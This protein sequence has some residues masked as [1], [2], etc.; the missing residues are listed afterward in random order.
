MVSRQLVVT[1][2]L[3]AKLVPVRR[4]AGGYVILKGGG[5]N[6]GTLPLPPVSLREGYGVR[7]DLSP[8]DDQYLDGGKAH[9]HTMMA[10]L[11]SAG[12]ELR[13]GQRLLELGCATGRMLRWFAPHAESSEVWGVDMNA[14]SIA[15]CQQ[16]LS[17]PFHFVTTTTAPHLPF[18]DRSFDLV[19]AGSVF[20][21]I[22]ELADAWL[23]E[24]RRVLKPGA[25][26]YVTIFDDKSRDA[27]LTRF[28]DHPT[29]RFLSDFDRRT[30]V[31]ASDYAS[32]VY[33]PSC[34]DVRVVYDRASLLGKVGRWFVVKTVRD[35]AYGWQTGVVLQKR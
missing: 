26:A 21:H 33:Q 16:H 23:L 6:D 13:V 29:H 25:L 9:V 31:L 8:D 22:A 27:L 7:P 24:V 3:G 19:Y 18:E 2:Q 12:F 20:T 28:V 4:K 11:E 15:W 32:F 10:V 5:R 34:R 30:G 17:P 1:P 35:E 14:L